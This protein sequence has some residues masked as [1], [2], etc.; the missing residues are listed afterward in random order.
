[1]RHYLSRLEETVKSHWDA[2]ALC[3]WKGE[4]FTFGQTAEYIEKFHLLFAA[5]GVEKMD[6]SSNY[7]SSHLPVK[8]K[9]I[10]YSGNT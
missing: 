2:P 7:G 10:L 3:N 1:M 8:K 9:N 4:Q 5:A 6:S